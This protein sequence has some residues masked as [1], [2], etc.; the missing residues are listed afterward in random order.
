MISL[1]HWFMVLLPKFL[2]WMLGTYTQDLMI[3]AVT[4]QMSFAF[5]FAIIH[6]VHIW[7][8]TVMLLI[9]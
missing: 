1:T 4:L 7:S 9:T 2:T 3:L 6:N 5:L 8:L